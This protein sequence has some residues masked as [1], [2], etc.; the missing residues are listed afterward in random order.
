MLRFDHLSDI[1]KRVIDERPP[2]V[3]DFFEEFSRNVREQKFHLPERFPPD[4]VF[5]ETPMYKVAQKQLT[6]MKLPYSNES[7]AQQ[8]SAEDD[9]QEED[10]KDELLKIKLKPEPLV[11]IRIFNDRVQHLQFFWNQCGF[12]ISSDNIFQLACSMNRLQ[13]H[14]SIRECRFWGMINGLKASYYVVEAL[15]TNEECESRLLQME[16]EIQENEFKQKRKLNDD[17]KLESHIGPELTPGAVGWDNYPVEELMK[18]QPPVAEIPKIKFK[19]EFDVPPEPIGQGVNRY[20]YFVVN[21]LSDEWIELPLITPKQVVLS[22]QI[23]KFFTG[24]LEAEIISYPSF[25]GKEK[26]YLRAMIARIT[27]GTYIAPRDYYRKMTEK[28]RKLFEGKVPDQDNEEDE[29][30]EESEKESS[31]DEGEEEEEGIP[32]EGNKGIDL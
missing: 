9:I 7:I 12:S 4:A 1:I 6:S 20:S 11:S 5:E 3:I 15:L 24:D 14:H 8:V 21:S 22:R 30:E 29:E 31:I 28:E 13:T 27:A 2:N 10:S 26:H 19:E 25:N 32:G 18:M 23:K 16:R 17:A